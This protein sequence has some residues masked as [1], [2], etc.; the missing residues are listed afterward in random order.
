MSI[1]SIASRGATNNA[2]QLGLTQ[3]IFAITVKLVTD[4]F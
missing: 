4:N 1:Q 2:P 3:L